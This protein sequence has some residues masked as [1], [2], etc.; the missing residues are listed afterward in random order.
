MLKLSKALSY[1]VFAGA[2]IVLTVAAK[3]YEG[4]TLKATAYSG[5]FY[6]AV[7]AAVKER[8]EEGTG[9]TLDLIPTDTDDNVVLMAAPADNP[10]YDVVMCPGI[11]FLQGIANELYLPLRKENVPNLDDLNEFH[12]S[13]F[14]LGFDVTYGIPFD[15]GIFAIGYN[16]ETLGFAPTSYADLWRPEAQGKIGLDAVWWYGHAGGVALAIDQAPDVGELYTDD[17]LDAMVEELQKLEVGMWW[18]T[19][20]EAT[21]SLQ[22]GDVDI[23]IVATEIFAPLVLAEPD[24]FALAVPQPT[25]GFMDYFCVVRGTKQRELGEVYLNYLLDPEVQRDWAELVPYYMSNANV[26]YG[27]IA[28][29]FLPPTEKERENF[30]IMLDYL[31]LG[32]NFDRIDE[33][34]KKDVYTK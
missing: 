30:G 23:G 25:H 34:F 32:D 15:F 28:T 3:P 13:D 14:G 2:A 27:P 1:V 29:Q 8:F 11:Q 20:A 17:G 7:K 31:W 4:Q 5:P 26:E 16:K 24:R 6:D 9:A 21:A 22:R 18:T 10:P 33:R 19:G 12:A